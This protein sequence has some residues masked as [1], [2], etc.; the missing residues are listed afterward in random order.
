MT[1]FL[2]F[3]FG[4]VIMVEGSHAY[5]QIQEN[6]PYGAYSLLVRFVNPDM[7]VERRLMKLILNGENPTEQWQDIHEARKAI[8]WELAVKRMFS[9]E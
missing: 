1:H 3:Y 7:T 4:N 6:A 2:Q 9:G 5:Y 8:G